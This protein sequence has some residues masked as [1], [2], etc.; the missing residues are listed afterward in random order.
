MP[1]PT[2]DDSSRPIPSGSLPPGSAYRW[3]IRA[4]DWAAWDVG[5]I[6]RFKV[7]HNGT[8]YTSPDCPRD[9][10]D[11]NNGPSLAWTGIPGIY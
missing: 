7:K 10:P 3:I 5:T 2:V 4:E 11:Y 1:I 9:I 8:E 6:L